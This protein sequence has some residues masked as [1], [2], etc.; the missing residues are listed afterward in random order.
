MAD[1]EPLHKKGAD[2]S[3]GAKA[4]AGDALNRVQNEAPFIA[5]WIETNDKGEQVVKWSKANVN[6]QIYCFMALALMEFAQAC[7]RQAME[8]ENG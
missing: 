5:L 1:I 3:W 4:C 8:R 7:V 2:K 6:Y